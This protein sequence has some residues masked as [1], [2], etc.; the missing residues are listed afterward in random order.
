MNSKNKTIVRI[1]PAGM[2]LCSM[3]FLFYSNARS[4]AQTVIQRCHQRTKS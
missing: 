2:A 1:K 3:L 4:E